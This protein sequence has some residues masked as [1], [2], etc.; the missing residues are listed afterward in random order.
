MTESTATIE[1]EPLKCPNCGMD[2][3]IKQ[4]LTGNAYVKPN[5]WFVVSY[6]DWEAECGCVRLDGSPLVVKRSYE[7]D[8]YRALGVL[9]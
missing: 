1:R 3:R 6:E 5:N 7:W 8:L 9:V 2:Y 4:I